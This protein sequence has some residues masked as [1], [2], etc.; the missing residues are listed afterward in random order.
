MPVN[1]LRGGDWLLLRPL[2]PLRLHRRS[3]EGLQGGVQQACSAAW[4][5]LGGAWPHKVAAQQCGGQYRWVPGVVVPQLLLAVPP[6][7]PCTTAQRSEECRRTPG[8]GRVVSQ[9]GR[10]QADGLFK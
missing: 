9:P 7:V 6:G 10:R 1:E 3:V 5:H 2:P 4:G 8:R